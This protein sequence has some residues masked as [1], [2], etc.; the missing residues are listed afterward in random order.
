MKLIFFKLFEIFILFKWFNFQKLSEQE[1]DKYRAER[2]A[3]RPH[4]QKAVDEFW[5]VIYKWI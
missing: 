4:G 3:R 5:Y 2:L 1:K